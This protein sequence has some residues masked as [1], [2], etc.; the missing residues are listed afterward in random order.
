MPAWCYQTL[1]KTIPKNITVEQIWTHNEEMSIPVHRFITLFY[2]IKATNE[3]LH[4][5][6]VTMVVSAPL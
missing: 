4:K 5:Y 2:V 1:E 3:G 6:S